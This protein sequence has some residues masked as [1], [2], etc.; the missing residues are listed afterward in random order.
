MPAYSALQGTE[1]A[2]LEKEVLLRKYRQVI[3]RKDRYG[4]LIMQTRKQTAELETRLIRGANTSLA[5]VEFQTLVEAAAQ[6]WQLAVS[7]RNV[8]PNTQ[9]KEPVRDMT[10][11]LAFDCTPQQLVGFLAELRQAPKSIRVQ[12]MSISPVQLVHEMPKAGPF[13][14]DLKANMTLA[15]VISIPASEGGSQ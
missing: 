5:A 10:V 15:A 14:K 11:T 6:K 13:L 9:A 4:E 7:Q 12:A 2:A 1:T 8:T 3:G